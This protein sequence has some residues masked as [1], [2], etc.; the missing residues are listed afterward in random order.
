MF[1]L[2]CHPQGAYIDVVKTYNNH[3]KTIL[4]LYVLITFM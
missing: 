2:N 1:Q 4:L 3:C